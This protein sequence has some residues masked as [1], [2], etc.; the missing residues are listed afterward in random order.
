MMKQSIIPLPLT[1]AKNVR[2]LGG[3]HTEYGTVTKTHSLLRADALHNLTDADCKLLYDYGVRCIIDLR[4]ED[5][6]SR[7]V[8]RLP[9]VH[10]DVSYIIS[11][12]QDPV[13]A[14]RYQEAFPP[15]MWELYCW[16]LDD[17]AS[18]FR[19]VFETIIEYQD[20][21]VLF[22]CS[23]GKDRTGM[24]AMLLHQLAGV[25]E[26]T[27]VAEYTR[28]E[29]LMT[30]VFA[31]QT[32]EL[33]ARGLVVPQ[34]VMQSPPENMRK[35]LDYLRKNYGTAKDYLLSIGLTDNQI[36]QLLHKLV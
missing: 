6:R 19:T 29:A 14:H 17:S 5:E 18:E 36:I 13:R 9:I 2:E 10:S 21:A 12:L 32:A 4:T 30:E 26:D 8:D 22:H 11:S 34:Y 27:I 20:N 1:G 16:M 15:S 3:F 24:V 25:S 7:A 35:A 31:I 28:T 33:E 23:G